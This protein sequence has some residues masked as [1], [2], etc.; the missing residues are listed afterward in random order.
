MRDFLRGE[1]ASWHQI[2]NVPD[3]MKLLVPLLAAFGH[4]H[5]RS[6]NRSPLVNGFGDEHGLNCATNESDHGTDIRGYPDSEGQHGA[7]ACLDYSCMDH[8]VQAAQRSNVPS[9]NMDSCENLVAFWSLV[10]N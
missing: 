7:I 3:C 8:V 9:A 1:I 5:V 2:P 6:G 4:V 10:I